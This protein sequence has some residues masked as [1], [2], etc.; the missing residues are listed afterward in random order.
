MSLFK[1][2]TNTVK[3]AFV[4]KFVSQHIKLTIQEYFLAWVWLTAKVLKTTKAF[5]SSSS[6]IRFQ[7]SWVNFISWVAEKS[8]KYH[9]NNDFLFKGLSN[10]YNLIECK[11]MQCLAPSAYYP[12]SLDCITSLAWVTT[13]LILWFQSLKSK[14]SRKIWLNDCHLETICAG[15]RH[16]LT[17]PPVLSWSDENCRRCYTKTTKFYGLT[18]WWT[19]HPM[20]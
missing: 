8:W 13:V 10:W 14:C 11:D 2:V 5:S 4:S 9:L 16:K 12:P 20:I 7:V 1:C 18:N 6:V 3:Y 19:P 17:V 15:P